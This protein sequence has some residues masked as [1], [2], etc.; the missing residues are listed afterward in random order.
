MHRRAFLAALAATAVVGCSRPP[1]PDPGWAALARGVAWLHASQAE[2]GGFRSRTYGLFAEGQSLTPLVVLAL[3]RAPGP[4]PA[5]HARRVDAALR[6]A[7]SRL[8]AHGALGFAGAA[9]DYPCYATAMLV[10]ALVASGPAWASRAA[11]SV[12]WLDALQLRDGWE[13]HPGHGGFPMG[14]ARRPA[15]PDAGHVDL[16]MTRRATQALRAIGRRPDDPSLRA[17]AGFARRCRAP[18]AGF[19]YTPVHPRLNKGTLDPATGASQGYGSATCDGLLA[20]RAAGAPADDPDVVAGLRR[21]HAL[22]R[23]DR[24]PGLE[25]GPMAPFAPA[26]VHYYRAGA[27]EVFADLGGPAGWR[28]A[29]IAAILADQ[30]EDGAWRNESPLQKEDDPLVATALAVLALGAALRPPERSGATS[31]GGPP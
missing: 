1:P 31:A 28:P 14:Y 25:G 17:A 8:D 3:Q 30:H 4:R 12:A 10:S 16:S 13:E 6:Y 29:L 5:D 9:P 24:N 20:L 7:L 18:D 15:P 22:H 23:V 21:L 26:M 19:V 11:P 2:D 27:A